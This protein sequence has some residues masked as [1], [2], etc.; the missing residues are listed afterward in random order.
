M[1]HLFYSILIALLFMSLYL[2]IASIIVASSNYDVKTVGYVDFPFRLPK[3]LFFYFFP[4][5]PED[6]GLDISV[7]RLIIGFSVFMMNLFLYSIPAYIVLRILRK[8]KN[9]EA[10]EALNENPPPP[11]TFE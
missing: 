10:S 5:R 11:P 3:I 1:K 4:A 2:L 9:I 7:R 8:N 6:Y